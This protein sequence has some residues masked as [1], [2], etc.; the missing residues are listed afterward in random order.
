M[1]DAVVMSD[2]RAGQS[3]RWRLA[4][5][6]PSLSLGVLLAWLVLVPLALVLIS[7][8]KPTGF[9]PYHI[10]LHCTGMD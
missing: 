2:Q 5:W 9:T 7:S 4:R 10:A 6:L 1:T 3:L 8:F